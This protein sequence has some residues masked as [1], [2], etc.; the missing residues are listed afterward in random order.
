LEN[1]VRLAAFEW[2]RSL[3]GLYDGAIPRPILERGFEFQGQ[4]VTAVGPTGI[5]KPRQF[6]TIPLSITSTPDGPYDDTIGDDGL[7]VYKYR[8]SNPN[9]RDNVALREAWRTRTPLIYFLGV[10]P[11]RYLPVWPVFILEDHPE[12]LSCV[13]AIDPAYA[14]GSNSGILTTTRYEEQSESVLSIRR[15]IAAFTRRRLH[16]TAFREAVVSAYDC[17]CALCRLKHR[18]LLDAAH[19]IADSLPKGDPIVPNGLCL[20]K[21]H[22]AAF[23][24]NIVGISP[25]YSVHVRSD[26]LAEIDGPMLRHGLQ[27]LHRG[28]LVIPSRKIDRPDPERLESRFKEFLEAS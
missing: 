24:Q 13:V 1:A 26:I 17:T 19:I 15:Y 18:E 7:L 16:Q 2:V 23:D 9:H 21:I 14:L 22:H 12:S 10:Y 28:K 4:R 25:D 6:K 5:W 8:G 11:G 20:C 27:G 3:N